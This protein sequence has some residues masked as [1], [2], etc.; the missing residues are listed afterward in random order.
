MAGAAWRR[1]SVPGLL[2]GG[3]YG[4]TPRASENTAVNDLNT[5]GSPAVDALTGTTK[6]KFVKGHLL[7]DNLG[8]PGESENLTPMTV[9][10]HKR[11]HDQVEA[12]LKKALAPAR[13]NA[14]YD[15]RVGDPWFGVEFNA[16]VKGQKIPTGSPAE[17]A[18]ADHIDIYMNWIT[19]PESGGESDFLGLQEQET[20][21]L[22]TC[23]AAASIPR[24]AVSPRTQPRRPVRADR[25]HTAY[26][27]R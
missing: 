24:P 5:H 6:A 17:Q 11:F 10:A 3:V 19:K 7:N 8:G 13:Q 15:S 26:S 21:R 14:L 9:L 2:G 12:P 1:S 22:R 25:Y 20:L 4:S 18:I 23:R 27:M 16:Y